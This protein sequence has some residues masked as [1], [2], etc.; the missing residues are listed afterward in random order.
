M[1]LS[2]TTISYLLVDNDIKTNNETINP[3]GTGRTIISVFGIYQTCE[4]KRI[5][6]NIQV[7][8]NMLGILVSPFFNRIMIIIIIQAYVYMK[9]PLNFLLFVRRRYP[10]QIRPHLSRV[11]SGNQLG[12]FLDTT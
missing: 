1:I 9:K 3:H 8:A 11:S 2:L 4:W 7:H 10:S 12:W 6:K 5:L